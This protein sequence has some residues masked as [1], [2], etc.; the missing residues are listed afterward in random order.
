MHSLMIKQMV[1][2]GQV[3]WFRTLKTPMTTDW[4]RYPWPGV[5]VWSWSIVAALN[6]S[7]DF[8]AQFG[9]FLRLCDVTSA[10]F[11]QKFCAVFKG[12]C[13]GDFLLTNGDFW[14]LFLAPLSSYSW[15]TCMLTETLIECVLVKMKINSKCL[16]VRISIV[17]FNS[18]YTR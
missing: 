8:V 10:T 3:Q 15:Y 12:L 9:D 14:K 6:W 7:R 2:P 18:I 5:S 13:L 17:V 4:Q 11:R 1:V 16:V